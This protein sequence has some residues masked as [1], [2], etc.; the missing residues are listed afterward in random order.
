MLGTPWRVSPVDGDR[1][2][3]ARF[4]ESVGSDTGGLLFIIFLVPSTL[5]SF[6]PLVSKWI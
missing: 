1:P 6:P 2:H 5:V 4:F 3:A